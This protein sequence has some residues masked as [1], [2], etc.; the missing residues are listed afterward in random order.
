MSCMWYVIL[1]LHIWHIFEYLEYFAYLSYIECI[2]LIRVLLSFVLSWCRK[3]KPKLTHSGGSTYKAGQSW[4]QSWFRYGSILGR[5]GCFAASVG[6]E[7]NS[8][9]TKLMSSISRML[10]STTDFLPLLTS[11]L[12][13]SVCQCQASACSLLE[14]WSARDWDW[15]WLRRS[16]LIGTTKSLQ[17]RRRKGHTSTWLL[18][19]SS[20][21]LLGTRQL[22][23]L[24]RRRV[25]RGGGDGAWGS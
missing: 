5:Q 18:D 25:R 19:G 12:A 9:H 22:P 7:L 3:K 2:C 13:S 10:R 1:I 20:G 11:F 8:L 15:L 4:I 6:P 17:S 21:W 14:G 23:V 24:G 16:G